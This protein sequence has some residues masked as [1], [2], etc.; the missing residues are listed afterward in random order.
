MAQLG[1]TFRIFVSS[2]FTDLQEERNALQKEVFPA[3]KKLCT[4]RG[5]Q[6]QAID[7]RWGI[8][9]EASLDQRTMR[10][11]KK[12][13][14]SCQRT[15]PKPNFILLLGDRYGWRPLPEEIPED[16]FKEIE[17]LVKDPE[18]KKLLVEWYK[19][20]ENAVPTAI[21]CLQP[22]TGEYEQFEAWD[23]LEKKLHSILL[24]AANKMN[25]GPKR[26]LSP[27]KLVS[28]DRLA[29]YVASATEQE[30][31][32]GAL[33]VEDAK[34]HVFCFFRTI[35]DL[36]KD[37]SAKDFV[38]LRA[39]GEP[40][41]VAKDFLDGLKNCLENRLPGNI[42][43]YEARWTGVGITTDHIQK[44][45][46]DVCSSLEKV[47]LSEIKQIES[48]PQLE[49]EV[50]DHER[51]GKERA[52]FF[53]GR[54]SVLERISAYISGKN[55]HPL[56]IYGEG[57]SGKSAL[58]AFALEQAQ[59]EHSQAKIGFRFIG[60]TLNSADGRALLEDLCRQVSRIYGGDEAVPTT[61]QELVEEFP[62]RL[63]L[64]TTDN[65]LVLFLDS[66]DQL[67]AAHHARSLIWLPADLPENVRLIVTTRPGEYL[68]ALRN[69]LPQDNI[70]ELGPLSLEEGSILLDRW[71]TAPPSRQ[72]QDFQR[73]EVLDK[74]AACRW[75]LYLKLAFEEARLWKSDTRELKLS[76]DIKGIIKD[77]L[78]K[79]LEADH[80]KMLIS[81]FFGYM[82]ASREMNGL[83]EDEL[84][85]ILSS[86]K[87]FFNDFLNR[88]KH[89]PP[90]P[91]LPVAVWARLYFD[92][93]S[94]LSGR[95]HEGATLLSFFHRELGDVAKSAYLAEDEDK[96]QQVLAD[97]F[98]SKADPEV[99]P[100]K[101]ERKKTWHGTP[102]ALSE[103]PF[104]LTR[105]S[106]W[107]EVFET[108]VDFR[109]LEQKAA[110]VGVMENIDAQG[111]RTISYTGALA[112][113]EDFDLALG[114]FPK[115]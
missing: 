24:Q 11:C 65:P 22:R 66:L 76:Q 109:F 79:R 54:T 95:S 99:E 85:E 83:A 106:R 67:S 1:R 12:E 63:A 103:L 91:K 8:G 75:P 77:N 45:C 69:K 2:T 30:I 113:L 70:V 62:K 68:V 87:E 101:K 28:D 42:F 6:F 100:E 105:A 38:D 94:Y 32:D 92:L 13:L 51:F 80:G 72:L 64:A 9:E 49:K 57:G 97:Y 26:P 16:E 4:E 112:L 15:S 39:D 93:E 86:D 78:F 61:Y 55:P 59:R 74:F 27:D 111:K 37:K 40:D 58:T 81:R 41:S 33:S 52:K 53:V 50:E 96:F 36:P 84:L 82:A 46:Y 23:P 114:S 17:R 19:P 21:Y 48:K 102:R 5:C 98:L 104:H 18:E 14:K 20:D 73:K 110:R 90:E 7:L 25:L 35:E 47:I 71:L 29:K 89:T 31:I 88:V 108:L 10:I 3:L 107:D 115:E 43:K 60:A 34:E 44:L 56:G